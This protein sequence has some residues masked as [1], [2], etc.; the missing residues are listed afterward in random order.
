MS[1]IAKASNNDGQFQAG[2]PGVYHTR[3]TSSSSAQS[4]AVGPGTTLVWLKTN[5][6]C[7]IKF[8]ADP[9]ATTSHF[10]LPADEWWS[11][12]ILP[13]EKIAAIRVSEDG[14]LLI[15]EAE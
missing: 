15:N 12:S 13:G 11:F 4:A 10:Q 9:T 2:R 6:A 8:G 5:K 1:V 7:H 14:T 3:S